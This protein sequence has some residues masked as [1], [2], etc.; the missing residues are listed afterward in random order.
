MR[1]AE[2]MSRLGTE[3]AFEV[4]AQVN[5]LRAQGR[6]IMAFSIGE[7]DFDTPANIRAAAKKALDE[8]FTHYNPSAGLPVLREAAA[9]EVNR[10][11]GTSYTPEN[12]VVVPGGKPII[13][14]TI[15]SLIEKGDEVIYPN[16]GFPIYESMINFVGGKAVPLPLVEKHA[17]SFDPERLAA[18]V[19]DRTRLVILNSPQNPTGGVVP[20]DALERL[21][22]L[23]KKHDFMILSDEIYSRLVYNGTFQSI[24]RFDGMVDRTIVL[25]GHSKTYAMTGWR[26]GYGCMPK[27]LAEQMALLMVNSN[28]CTATF[29]QIAGAEALTGPQA[30]ADAMKQTFLERRDLVVG[31]LN[32]IEGIHCLVPAGAFYVW[33]NVTGVCEK[34]GLPDSRALQD[35]LLYEGGVAALGRHCFGRRAD[36]EVQEYLRFSYAASSEVIRKGLERVA[37]AVADSARAEK[38]LAAQK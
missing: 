27:E 1:L 22:D 6:D 24:T 35:Y 12:V 37:E 21:A 16:P 2:R 26:L 36:D 34:L 5:A 17:F 32:G 7:P 33:P 9:A 30:D 38:F 13:F 20:L 18:L 29:T 11:R 8:G 25:D 4:L 14:Y 31:L 15:L 10:T 3:T 19:T 28:S 23:A